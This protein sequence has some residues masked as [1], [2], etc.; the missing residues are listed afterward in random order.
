MKTIYITACCILTV[1]A[2]A[3]IIA[4]SHYGGVAGTNQKLVQKLQSELKEANAKIEND[5]D[6]ISA[7]RD[8]AALLKN[9]LDKSDNDL[10]DAESK[11]ASAADK[12]S[13]YEAAD[14]TRRD[15]EAEKLLVPPP[16]DGVFSKVVGV[17]GETLAVNATFG[18][19]IG[20]KL[21]FRPENQPPISVDVDAIH[22]IILKYLGIDAAAAKQQQ[23]RLD[24]AWATKT[25]AD[26]VKAA[27]DYQA[28]LAQQQTEA[29]LAIEK[30][31]ADAAQQA[32]LAA[33][34]QA[35]ADRENADAAMINAQKPPPQINVIQ[36][37]QQNQIQQNQR[38]PHG[39]YLQNGVWYQY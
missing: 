32:A 36:Q 18:E 9:K 22:P 6:T 38:P 23:S 29:Q 31:K 37:S 7:D 21:I 39:Y 4:S 34:Q 3:A 13:S 17:K 27:L 14:Q 15:E 19:Q 24:S 20:R 11:L 30:Q 2:G 16:V 35:Q 25:Q 1:V 33:Q 28:A 10:A 26:S 12:I 8:S 5:A